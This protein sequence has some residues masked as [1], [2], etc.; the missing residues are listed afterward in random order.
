[1]ATLAVALL[2]L[3]VNRL[4][5]FERQSFLNSY[6]LL[7]KTVQQEKRK[8]AGGRELLALFSNPSTVPASS[9]LPHPHFTPQT[10]SPCKNRNTTVTTSCRMSPPLPL[11]PLLPPPLLLM[12]LPLLMPLLLP[13]LRMLPLLPLLLRR[14]LPPALMLAAHLDLL[15]SIGRHSQPQAL[16]LK[17]L[18]LGQELK[19]LLRSIPNENVSAEGGSHT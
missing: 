12:P 11:P 2:L 16:G 18:Q 7:N 5:R 13:L 14:R 19:F 10:L 6:V 15:G 1:M 9:S 4:N 3:A 8:R 17:P